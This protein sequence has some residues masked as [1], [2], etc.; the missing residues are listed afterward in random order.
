MA[1]VPHFI[2]PEGPIASVLDTILSIAGPNFEGPYQS[3]TQPHN[4]V[5]ANQETLIQYQMPGG[6]QL[7]GHAN[8]SSGG[9]IGAAINS[10]IGLLSPAIS[11][12]ALI[13][14]ILGV[15]RGIIEVLCCLMNP[16]CVNK[17]I[18]RLFK[19]WIPPFISL[20]PPLAGV[21]IM[22]ST[23]KAI[24]AIADNPYNVG[25]HSTDRVPII[26]TS[27]DLSKLYG[28][29]CRPKRMRAWSYELDRK[30]IFSIAQGEGRNITSGNIGG[31]QYT[32]RVE[33]L[34]MGNFTSGGDY[35]RSFP[36]GHYDEHWIVDGGNQR[37]SSQVFVLAISSYYLGCCGA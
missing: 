14:P 35:S 15:I 25:N 18:I 17:A 28:A 1:D 22:A 6:S 13:L 8:P 7:E 2:D 36:L 3:S 26:M 23:I 21:V 9:N 16:F 10:M 34:P 4:M 12:F 11:A 30:E 5:E 33:F 27:N 31:H 19:K 24:M 29:L 37:R 20:Y 32:G